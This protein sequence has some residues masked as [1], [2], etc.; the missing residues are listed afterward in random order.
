[1]YEILLEHQQEELNGYLAEYAD[2]LDLTFALN[3]C[4]ISPEG[5][6]SRINQD[7]ESGIREIHAQ[8]Y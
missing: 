5:R 6:I 1:M 4:G 7:I 8:L 3:F 2:R